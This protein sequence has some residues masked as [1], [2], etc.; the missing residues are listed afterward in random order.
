MSLRLTV[1]VSDI[2]Y[3]Q[4]LDRSLSLNRR[5]VAALDAVHCAGRPIIRVLQR[6][7]NYIMTNPLPLS[8]Y[9]F[10]LF[11]GESSFRH[12]LRLFK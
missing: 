12:A 8:N 4:I 6:S 3:K 7:S 5:C 2:D 9:T 11:T 10:V 1:K